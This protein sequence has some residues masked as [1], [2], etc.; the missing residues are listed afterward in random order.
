MVRKIVMLVTAT[1]LLLG[2]TSVSDQLKAQMVKLPHHYA[3]FDIKMG[4]SVTTGNNATTIDGIIQNV[5]YATMED[6]EVW[7]S[8]SDAKGTVLARSVAYIIPNRLDRD[9]SAPFTVKLPLAVSAT[10]KL[11]F[12]YKYTGADGGSMDG[13][14]TNWMQSFETTPGN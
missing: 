13:G 2:F 11:L 6:I 10:T 14:V 8:V 9:D 5:R 12:T 3:Q 7:V 1:A 4:W